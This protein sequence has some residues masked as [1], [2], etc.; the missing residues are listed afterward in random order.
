MIQYHGG[1]DTYREWDGE[2][3]AGG[4]VETY[5]YG[6]LGWRSLS[7]H[8]FLTSRSDNNYHELFFQIG[9]ICKS[10]GDICRKFDSYQSRHMLKD[11]LVNIKFFVP[12]LEEAKYLRNHLAQRVAIFSEPNISISK[13][14]L[15]AIQPKSY[16]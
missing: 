6:T 13:N 11:T 3:V 4:V 2:T 5:L 9:I 7:Y 1:G 15:Y 8:P 10:L 12:T 14:K 16:N